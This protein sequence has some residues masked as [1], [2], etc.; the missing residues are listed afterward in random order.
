MKTNC[1]FLS[2]PEHNIRIVYT[3]K[4]SSW[5]NQIEIWFSIIKR[6]LLNKRASFKSVK[7]MEKR[8]K[9]YIDY[10]NENIAKPFQW[11]YSGK[12]LKA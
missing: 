2:N 12:L 7:E 6:H 5:L 1:E 10:Y 11:T 9:E 3:P 8:I 4:H